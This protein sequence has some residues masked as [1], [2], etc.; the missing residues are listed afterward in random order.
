MIQ[1]IFFLI[2]LSNVIHFMLCLIRG[3][4]EIQGIKVCL[5]QPRNMQLDLRKM[6]NLKYLIVH[7]VICKDLKFLPNELRLIDWLEFSLSSI[8]SN[9]FLQ[10]LVVLNMLGSHIQLDEHFEVWTLIF[11]NCYFFKQY[12]NVF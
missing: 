9:F 6:K 12:L 3:V 7:N 10:K 11:I 1:Y 4:D 2:L 8:P 5:L